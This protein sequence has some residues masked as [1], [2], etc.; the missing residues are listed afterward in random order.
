MAMQTLPFLT[1]YYSKISSSLNVI[2]CCISRVLANEIHNSSQKGIMG[3]QI[4]FTVLQV[5][6]ELSCLIIEKCIRIA[7]FG[8][9]IFILLVEQVRPSWAICEISYP[10]GLVCVLSKVSRLLAPKSKTFVQFAEQGRPIKK[11]LRQDTPLRLACAP[12]Y[13]SR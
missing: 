10:F 9:Q 1:K 7:C 5:E 4:L 8:S 13:R 6:F 2:C 12:N 3:R 11:L